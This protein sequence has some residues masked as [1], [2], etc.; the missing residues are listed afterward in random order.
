MKNYLQLEKN[1]YSK[2]QRKFK[3]DANQNIQ[4]YELIFELEAFLYQCKSSLD[5][6]VKI[7]TPIVGPRVIKTQT[8]GNKG[9][10]TIKGLEQY[11]HNKS[12]NINAINAINRLIVLIKEN[13]DAWLKIIIEMRDKLCHYTGLCNY[14]FIPKRLPN[15]DI[16]PEKPKIIQ[17]MATDKFLNLVYNNN[18]Q[19]QQDF[20]CM[21]LS[22]RFP[23][24]IDLMEANQMQILQD[25]NNHEAAKYIKYSVGMRSAITP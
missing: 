9:E 4:A 8:F 21:A 23:T 18:I 12:V 1:L 13:Q 5:I 3:K 7:L 15:G 22:I 17:L 25:H 11:K 19:F 20:F 2:A 16:V 24:G 10:T 14:L 6:M